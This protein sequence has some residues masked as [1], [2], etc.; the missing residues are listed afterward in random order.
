MCKQLKAL[1]VAFPALL[2]P[3]IAFPEIH[4]LTEHVRD[5]A[6]DDI[7]FFLRMPSSWDGEGPARD[8]FGRR[9]PTVRGVLAL[10]SW[11][12]EP[13]DVQEMLDRRGRFQHYL[14]WAERN[15]MAVIT[16]TNFRG[17]TIRESGDEL[18]EEDRDRV[19]EAFDDRVTEWERGFRRLCRKFGLPEENVL[20]YG[21]SGG[22]QLAH[23]LA[24]RAPEHFF[25]VHI[26]VNSSYDLPR[27]GG[28]E[29]I[30]MVTT[31][32]LEAG[33]PAAKRFYRQALDLGYHMIFKA[34]ENLGHSDSPANRK[35]SL[36]FFDFCLTFLPD[37]VD[38]EWEPPPEEWEYFMR[39][40]VYLGDWYNQIVF[41]AK[42]GGENIPPE[43]LVSLPTR[44]VAEA[45]GV[46]A[47]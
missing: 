12:A 20:I 4:T 11:R 25:A 40:P 30:W 18:S 45:W 41:P 22:G 34:E 47:E 5:P 32:T 46:I 26:H 24:L 10:C 39:Y 15:R 1:G 8:V 43:F 37:A 7:T 16:W 44:R 28:E 42:T 17:Y 35:L 2:F 14:G 19:D 23:R 38:P 31:G 27:R 9:V 36:A 3:L 13:A 33:Y 29:M 21:L 6:F